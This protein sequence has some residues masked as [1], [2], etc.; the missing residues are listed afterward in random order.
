MSN[1]SFNRVL[2]EIESQMKS[3]QSDRQSQT[4]TAKK[5]TLHGLASRPHDPV[6]DKSKFSINFMKNFIDRKFHENLHH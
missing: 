1:F 4:L 2:S 3:R 6:V 5:K